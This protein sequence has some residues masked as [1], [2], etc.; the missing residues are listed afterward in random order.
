MIILNKGSLR[1]DITV[2]FLWQ[3]GA[4]SLTEGVH[5]LVDSEKYHKVWISDS[6]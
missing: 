5:L 4:D 1:H 6:I 2:L 3:D